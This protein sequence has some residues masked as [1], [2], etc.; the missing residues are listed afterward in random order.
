MEVQARGLL[1]I[2]RCEQGRHGVRR[3]GRGV[4]VWNRSRPLRPLLP[5]KCLSPRPLLHCKVD[6]YAVCSKIFVEIVGT[7]RGNRGWTPMDSS[8]LLSCLQ[9]LYILV[10][11]CWVAFP[12]LLLATGT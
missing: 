10:F 12:S 5:R 3:G 2:D 7:P 8:S 4:C 1:R 6:V 11:S 9:L